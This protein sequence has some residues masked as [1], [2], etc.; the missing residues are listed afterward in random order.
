MTSLAGKRCLP[1]EGIIDKLTPEEAKKLHA[2][3]PEWTLSEDATT[4]T[5]T[6]PFKDFAKALAFANKVGEVAEA[7]WH[8]PD[9]R[10]GWGK[11]EV[12]FTTHSIRGLAENDFIM[13]AKVDALSA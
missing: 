10:V 7:E 5:R 6:F 8:H 12:Q 9:M 2:D 1:C 11:V 4:L 3:V 13:A